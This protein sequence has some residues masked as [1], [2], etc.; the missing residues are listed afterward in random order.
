VG[1]NPVA[2]TPLDQCHD[3]GTCDSGT[4]LCSNP[5]KQNGTGCDD[6]NTCTLADQ[7]TGGVCIGDPQTC[8]DGIVQ[9]TCGEECDDGGPSRN[10]SA[11]CRFICGPSPQVGCRK[12]LLSQKALVVLK[13]KNLDKRDAIS[14]KWAKGAATTTNEFGDPLSATDYTLCVY[15]ESSAPQPLLLVTVPAGGTCG[16]KPCWQAVRS[17]FRFKDRGL[18]HGVALTL[19]RGGS[20]GRAKVILRGKGERLG[21]TSLPLTPKVTIQLKRNDDPGLCWDAEYSTPLKNQADQFK[22]RAD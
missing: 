17:G 8:G 6:G 1:G 12:P 13:D 3:A 2:C 22:A 10:C 18:S 11:Q 5:A 14:W 16:I 7:C 21:M 9:A 19:L 15:D 4:G 20:D